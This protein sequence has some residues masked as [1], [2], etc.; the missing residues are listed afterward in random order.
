MRLE[1]APHRMKV[2]PLDPILPA[3]ELGISFGNA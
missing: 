3:R 2:V 1:E